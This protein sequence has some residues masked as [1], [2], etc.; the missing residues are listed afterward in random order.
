MLL[1]NLPTFRETALARIAQSP[2]PDVLVLGGGVNGVAVL[3]DLALNGVSAVLLD[4][5]DFCAGASSASTRM[6]HGG[7]RYLE[8]REF[9]LVAEA[10]RERNLLLRHAAHLVRPLEIVVPLNGVVRGLFGAALRFAGLSKKSGEM[11]L[12]ALKA[13]LVLYE[14]FGAVERMLPAHK[15]TTDTAKF[16]NGIRHGTRA[17][18]QYFD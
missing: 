16:P 11:C 2:A 17:V 14:R 7:L 12:V 1:P 6:A 18:V 15:A 13:G 4:R 9:R 8:G 10:A 5:G 3:R